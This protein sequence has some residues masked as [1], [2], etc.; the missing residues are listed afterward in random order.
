[1]PKLKFKFL[2]VLT[3]FF[4]SI[5]QVVVCQQTAIIHG[6][7]KDSLG[8]PLQSVLVGVSGS[9]QAPV[10]SDSLGRYN[11]SVP[12]GKEIE[13]GYIHF[14]Y[15][16]RLLKIKLKEGEVSEYNV[17]LYFQSGQV[18]D[19]ASITAMKHNSQGLTELNT[20]V[21]NS[22]PM[23]SGDFLSILTTSPG[24]VTRSELGSEYSVR[25]GGYD[26]NLVYV[27]GIEVYR[28]FLV[29]NGEQEGLSFINP[30]MVSSA[31]F[32]AG[33]FEAQY[34]DKMSSVL[35]VTYKKPSTFAGSVSGSLLGGTAHVE[36]ASKNRRF[37]YIAGIRYKTNQYLLNSLDVQG[38]YKPK[39]ADGQLFMTYAFTDRLELDILGNVGLNIYQFVPQSET[40]S[41]GT[42]SQAYQL[43]VYFQGQE[44]DQYLTLTG[45][46]S[47][48]YKASEKV[49]LRLIA[50]AYNDQ[51][52]QDYDVLGQYLISELNTNQGS[53][54]FGTP[55]FDL[56]VGS[57]LNHARDDINA[58]VYSF[59]H[60]G[61]FAYHTGDLLLW[62]AT[63]Q[64]EIVTSQISQWNFVDSAG[65][66]LPYNSYILQL[67]NVVKAF[68]TLQ[69]NR[70]M[71]Y[72]ENV[73]RWHGRDSSN[74]TLIITEGVRAN[75]WDVNGQ[76]AISPRGSIA[77]KPNWKR[78]VMFRFSTGLYYQPPF[79]RE[80]IDQYGSM[81]PGTKDQ[82]SIHYVLG[83]DY[84]FKAWGRP[85]KLVTEVY[86]KQLVN[87]IPYDIDNVYVNYF[88]TQTAHGYAAGIDSKIG[89]E[90]VKG[91]ESWASV[92]IL[93]ARYTINNAY[94]TINYNQYGQNVTYDVPDK[95]TAYSVNYPVGSLPLPLDQRVTFSMFFQ[96]YM[97]RFPNFKVNLNL[98]FGT[99]IPFGP[100][101]NHLYA[102]TL[103][104]PPYER[105]DI[106]G[107]YLIIGKKGKEGKRGLA[108]YFKRMWVGI[109]VFNL[110]QANNVISY[111]WVADVNGNKYAVPNYLTAR[112]VN[113]K[114]T[115]EF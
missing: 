29:E 110:L 98:V 20:G 114:L 96:D 26:E 109:E 8:Q 61:D 106:G 111:Q 41:F 64:H 94:Y 63:F 14:G 36:G 40:A 91:L 32:S 77:Y 34:G 60:K 80:I 82:E 112:E 25:G 83:S 31:F 90:F 67:Q 58:E 59:E 47:L 105:V 27:N 65:Y 24:V 113:V 100:P 66:S 87:V 56:G 13:I 10:Y 4:F 92:S 79:Y 76:T 1:M 57:Y 72:V 75:Y 30:D 55:S 70:V 42:V 54:A 16:G 6:V 102:D 12:A 68:D 103:R 51:E 88:P 81:Y 71:G 73:N 15:N 7:I 78:D 85:F 46:V 21:I 43:Q 37:T 49:N 115:M 89:G 86:Y 38:S 53:K 39:F 22:I 23:P 9:S 48:N 69:S 18:L 17:T 2:F 104:T 52:Q 93:D 33:G 5:Q 19:T 62:G 3:C 28:P 44:V 50:S 84:N 107:S 108:K 74:S 99:G 101:N 45:A 95:T 97:P 35:D 11:Y